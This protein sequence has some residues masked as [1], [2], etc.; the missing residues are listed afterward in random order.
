MHN[1]QSKW[2]AVAECTS[3]GY[4]PANCT[5]EKGFT[6]WEIARVMKSEVRERSYIASHSR[7]IMSKEGKRVRQLPG[8]VSEPTKG[9]GWQVNA[10]VR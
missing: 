6:S 5:C 3:C 7:H 1:N 10:E 4:S 2:Q 9:F 8:M